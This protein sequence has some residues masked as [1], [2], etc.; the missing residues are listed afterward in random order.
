MKFED[1]QDLRTLVTAYTLSIILN[2]MSIKYKGDNLDNSIIAY[3]NTSGWQEISLDN[4]L[5]KCFE[6]LKNNNTTCRFDRYNTANEIA[7]SIENDLVIKS[8]IYFDILENH[9]YFI[10]KNVESK[11][12]LIN[13]IETQMFLYTLK[14]FLKRLNFH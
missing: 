13:K 7:V 10:S 3:E 11:N 14:N 5:E 9:P 2:D 12:D 4:Y 8:S 1:I 6:F